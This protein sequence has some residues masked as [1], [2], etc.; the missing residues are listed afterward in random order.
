MAKPAPASIGQQIMGTIGT[1]VHNI[2]D[3]L[4]LMQLL[5]AYKNAPA[6]ATKAARDLTGQEAFDLMMHLVY[7]G[8]IELE[9]PIHTDKSGRITSPRPAQQVMI[10]THI[11]GVDYYRASS[12]GFP[13][14]YKHPHFAPTPAFA[15]VLYRLARMMKEKWGATRIVWGGIGAGHDGKSKNCHEVGT[16]VDFYGAITQKGTF[17]VLEDWGK[18]PI[19]NA[20]GTPHAKS[21]D[22]DDRWGSD[23]KTHYR[24]RLFGD[25]WSY[26]FFASV[27]AFA[28]EQCSVFSNDHPPLQFLSGGALGSGTI[29]HPDYSNPGLRKSHQ[30]HMHFQLGHAYLKENESPTA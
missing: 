14:N 12:K 4:H 10:K 17:D 8:E 21:T 13:G 6:A 18:K 5:D 23:T 26:W 11:A 16:C 27:Y 7:N 1:V 30:E 24:L 9:T 15:V 20:D 2:K 19:F 25:G 28:H 29:I 22:H 3:R